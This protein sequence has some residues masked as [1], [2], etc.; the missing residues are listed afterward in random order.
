[1]HNNPPRFDCLHC[2]TAVCRSSNPH[3]GCEYFVLWRFCILIGIC[4]VLRNERTAFNSM[5]LKELK[6][7][8]SDAMKFCF[9]LVSLPQNTIL[10]PTTREKTCCECLTF[11]SLFTTN[12]FLLPLTLRRLMFAHV[13]RKSCERVDESLEKI[14]FFFLYLLSFPCHHRSQA[15]LGGRRSF[16]AYFSWLHSYFTQKRL[17]GKSRQ[18]ALHDI[19][20]DC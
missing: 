7:K 16:A 17:A 4:I 5:T 8:F 18:V 15:L 13:M 12:T 11:H 2:S 3:R 10:H 1:M 6:I 20:L 14:F 9:V 19:Q